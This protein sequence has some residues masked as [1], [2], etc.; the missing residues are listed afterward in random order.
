MLMTVVHT[1]SFVPINAV[2]WIAWLG[3]R[4]RTGQAPICLG[5]PHVGFEPRI[6]ECDFALKSE[7]IANAGN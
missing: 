3:K 1:H 4:R 6:S 2:R 7:R 5:E